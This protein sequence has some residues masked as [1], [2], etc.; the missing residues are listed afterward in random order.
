MRNWIVGI[1]AAGLLLSAASLASAQLR[2]NRGYQQPYQQGQV[3]EEQY[4][5]QYGGTQYGGAQYGGAQYGGAQYGGAQYGGAQYGPQGGWQQQPY[6]GQPR[7]ANRPYDQGQL[8]QGGISQTD[9]ELA[10]CLLVDD[11][12]EIQLA[13]MAQERASSDDVKEF[14]KT[15]IDDHSK[16]VEELQRFAG[17]GRQTQ[18]AGGNR[19]MYGNRGGQLN[20][21]RLKQQLGQQC[22]ASS[23]QE[24]EE[25][26]GDEFDKCFIGMQIANHMK[27]VDTLKVFSRYASP[28]FD[29]A[30]EEIEQT[31]QEHLD[32]AKELIKQLEKEGHSGSSRNSSRSSD[33]S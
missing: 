13:R 25:K 14:A 26:E 19:Q 27:M 22:L 11:R 28:E 32:H 29:Q 7:M 8:G 10:Q 16:A 18:Q 9:Q 15:L 1:S 5:P 17:M 12:V 23:Q 6:G 4:G 20:L 33:R 24:L 2:R 3:Y 30:I 31:T 21:V